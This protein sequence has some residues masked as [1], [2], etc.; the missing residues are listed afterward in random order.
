LILTFLQAQGPQIVTDAERDAEQVSQVIPILQALP[1]GDLIV[2][3]VMLVLI[4]V[5][6]GVSMRLVMGHVLKRVR[7]VAL[8]PT[9]WSADVLLSGA[10]LMLLTVHLFETGLWTTLLV[11]SHLV[12]DWREAGYFA[13]NTYT[14][15]GYGTVILP[16][17]WKMLAPIIA[18]SGLF[19]FGW[20]GSVLVDIVGRVN[21]LK[22]LA[23]NRTP[24]PATDKPA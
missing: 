5:L 21:R 23:E 1:A 24:P 2:G 18:I 11:R 22:D 9:E 17:P 6:H 15:L 16:P 3:G 20:T 8:H 12:K 14:T 4:V 19:T 13:A 7:V 10:I